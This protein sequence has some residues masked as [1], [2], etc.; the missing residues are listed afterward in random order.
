M[1]FIFQG[2]V[3]VFHVTITTASSVN[4][5]E[6]LPPSIPPEHFSASMQGKKEKH[7]HK[8]LKQNK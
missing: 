2:K 5:T 3:L 8:Y 1:S 7:K 6:N 4:E